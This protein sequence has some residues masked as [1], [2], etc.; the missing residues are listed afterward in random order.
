[1]VYKNIWPVTNG[2]PSYNNILEQ[3]LI[4][5]L[6]SNSSLK[7]EEADFYYKRYALVLALDTEYHIKVFRG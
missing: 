3:F 5:E 6:L 7:A 4:N 2:I 1:M